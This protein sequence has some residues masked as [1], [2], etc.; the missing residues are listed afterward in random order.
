M[1]RGVVKTQPAELAALAQDWAEGHGLAFEELRSPKK[2]S[3]ETGD[4]VQY[5]A[6]GRLYLSKWRFRSEDGGATVDMTVRAKPWLSIVMHTLLLLGFGALL[7]LIS[8][9][10]WEYTLVNVL[11]FMGAAFLIMLLFWWREFRLSRRMSR[12]ESSF[13]EAAKLQYDTQQLTRS[14]M[15]VYAGRFRL[16]RQATLAGWA[17]LVGWLFLGL[18][19][20]IVVLF[21]CVLVLVMIAINLAR[22]KI[23]NWHWR[24]WIMDNAGRW[25]LLMLATLAIVPVLGT[26]E[27]FM[28]LEM[29]RSEDP[30]SV[31]EAIRQAGFRRLPA[32]AELLEADIRR[33][34]EDL[35]RPEAMSDEEW[36]ERRSVYFHGNTIVLFMIFLVM[37]YFFALRPFGK[38]L[39]SRE[40]WE[41]E[42][43][44]SDAGNGPYVPYLPEAS[45]WRIPRLLRSIVLVHYIF[46]GIIQLAAAAFCFEGF[47]YAFVGW[48]ILF[49]Q[50]A[51][52]WSWLFAICKILFGNDAGWATGML[53]LVGISL[54]VLVALGAFVRRVLANILLTARIGVNRLS[55]K[56]RESHRL[57]PIEEF[58]RDACLHLHLKRP[59]VWI[60]SDK[61]V[62]VKLHWLPV[63]G[64]S[65]I[66]ISSGAIKLLDEDELR[67]VVAH[68][69]GHVKQGVWKVGV[70]KLLS[71]VAFFPNH[72]LTLCL[73]WSG[74]E[75]DADRIA[76]AL[77]NDSQ[78][79]RNAL[80][81]ISMAQAGYLREN[82][83][84][85]AM[86]KIVNEIG[87][88]LK[89]VLGIRYSAIRFFFGDSLFGYAHPDVSERLNALESYLEGEHQNE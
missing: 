84:K 27:G 26:L 15:P 85:C 6:S 25:T 32:H 73:N 52:L 45:K 66:E 60:A 54:P 16:I 34:L 67:A 42:V 51:N 8:R 10:L 86:A 33:R 59:L 72:Y 88:C 40:Y 49:E 71:A 61:A 43:G 30:P 78:S 53:L 22:G 79:L 21:P 9:V 70:L 29:Y 12:L 2:Q 87:L 4:V 63:L 65:V 39:R 11:S 3:D 69:I 56:N 48:T 28:G 24:L 50:T 23:P 31:G 74:D 76:L 81:R 77:T 64:R 58:A 80:A 46:G 14:G 1:G 44:K 35:S 89:N 17:V 38:L 37:S 18:S 47:C 41:D 75:M 19:G 36:Q 5:E 68:E 20:A 82:S 83:D 13:W 7:H 62:N 55:G 57:R